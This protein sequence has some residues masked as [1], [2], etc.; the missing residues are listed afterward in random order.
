MSAREGWAYALL[1]LSL[2]WFAGPDEADDVPVP[3]PPPLL[4]LLLY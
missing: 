2:A 3:I 4:L 1:V